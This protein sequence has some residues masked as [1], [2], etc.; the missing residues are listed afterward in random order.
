[1]KKDSILELNNSEF[2]KHDTC[3]ID[4]ALQ[5]KKNIL[6]N[7][8]MLFRL[9]TQIGLPLDDNMRLL[10]LDVRGWLG[11][12]FCLRKM[13][14]LWACDFVCDDPILLPHNSHM[15]RLKGHSIAMLLNYVVS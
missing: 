1:M 8:A 11:R 6:V 3:E 15:G 4:L 10:A 7:Q 5:L 14:N 2:K 13:G 12:I 9:N